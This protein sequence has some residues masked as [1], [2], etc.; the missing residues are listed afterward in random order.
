MYLL[1][2]YVFV[3]NGIFVRYW[4]WVSAGCSSWYPIFWNGPK[5]TSVSEQIHLKLVSSNFRDVT[6]F[7]QFHL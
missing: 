4:E 3:A 6:L 2:L 5:T 1:Y 7:S